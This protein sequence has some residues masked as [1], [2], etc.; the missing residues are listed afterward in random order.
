M[1][2]TVCEVGGGIKK[3]TLVSDISSANVEA[4]E[5]TSSASLA[6]SV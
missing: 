4:V 1:G 5:N 6:M 3:Q 2:A